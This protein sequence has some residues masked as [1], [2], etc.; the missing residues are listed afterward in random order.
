MQQKCKYCDTELA[1]T[2][3]PIWETYCPNKACDREARN[4]RA[5][6]KEQLKNRP[7]A[8]TIDIIHK[9]VKAMKSAMETNQPMWVIESCINDMQNSIN[10]FY[11]RD[12]IVL[13]PFDG[14][15]D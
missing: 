15:N 11:N 7:T 12:M 10:D 2:G 9:Q 4:M 13:D 14:V 3:G 5:Y 1:E 6:I 8:K